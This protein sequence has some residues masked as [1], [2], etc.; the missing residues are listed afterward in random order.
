MIRG[1]YS[2]STPSI[3]LTQRFAGCPN[4]HLLPAAGSCCLVF[5]YADVPGAN[6]GDLC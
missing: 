4:G 1:R 5:S 3:L 6:F 2:E